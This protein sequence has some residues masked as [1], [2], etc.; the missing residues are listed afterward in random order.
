ML[1][2][3]YRLIDQYNVMTL[4]ELERLPRQGE[5]VTFNAQPSG[6]AFQEGDKATVFMGEQCR[7]S[8]FM[9]DRK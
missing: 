9:S 2:C 7:Q 5:H 8:T 3:T 6:A 1:K 4:A